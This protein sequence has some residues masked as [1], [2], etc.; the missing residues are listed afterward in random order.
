MNNAKN[1]VYTLTCLAIS[2]VI[3]AAFYEHLAVWP[4]AFAAP[5]ASLS[6]L[7]GEY[8]LNA[9]AFWSKIH[10]IVIFL[11]VTTL[12]LFW[13]SDR[14]KNILIYFI[15]YI[16][17]LV[18]TAFYFVPELVDITGTEYTS[19]MDADLGRRAAI[20]TKWSWLR[21]MILIP[22]SCILYY[23]L[24]KNLMKTPLND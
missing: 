7:Q 16:L 4:R 22:L 1:L 21:L 6:M 13:K 17:I 19:N 20:W 11:S 15:G 3:G 8:G 18:A 14:R 23:G 5:P 9:V 2:V 12:I 24:T 10:P